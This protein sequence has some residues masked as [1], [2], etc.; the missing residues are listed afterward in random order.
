MRKMITALGEESPQSV[1][2]MNNLALL[3]ENQ[4]LYDE[5]E[6]LFKKSHAISEQIQGS[7]HPTTLALLNNLAFLY[8]SQGDF[9]RSE[10]NYEKVIEL[11]KQ[12][13]GREHPNTIA[14]INN[15]AYLYL[16]DDKPEK[17]EPRFTLAYDPVSYTHL[18][19]P[20]SDLV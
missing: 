12:V 5:A 13:Y 14:S 10:L 18:T 4:G 9:Q 19:L 7:K 20:T 3:L 6:P 11:N 17:A 2:V 15:L 8:E 16:R 1:S